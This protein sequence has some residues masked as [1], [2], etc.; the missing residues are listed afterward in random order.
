MSLAPFHIYREHTASL[1]HG[2]GLWEP[3]PGGLYQQVAIG[4]VGFINNGYFVRMFNVQLE[5]NDPLNL[6]LL[7]PE[8][9]P[10]LESGPFVNI[11]QSSF[12][13]GDYYSRNVTSD[14]ARIDTLS[15]RPD[16]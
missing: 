4:D 15:A 14:R 1:Y 8:P 5:W 13:K 9:Y 3:D 10:R 7:T 11:S 16:E 12:P 2:H 6:T